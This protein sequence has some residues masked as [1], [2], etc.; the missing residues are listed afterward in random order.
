MARRRVDTP[1]HIRAAKQ[2]I[3]EAFECSLAGRGTAVVEIMAE[4]LTNKF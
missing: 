3:R 1:R 2:A 4:C